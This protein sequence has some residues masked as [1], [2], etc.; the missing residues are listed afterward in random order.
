MYLKL[1]FG[2]MFSGKTSWL[3]N[4]HKNTHSPDDT[5]FIN[6]SF[7]FNRNPI[8]YCISHDNIQCATKSFFCTTLSQFDTHAI[9]SKN[10]KNIFINEGQ[11]FNDLDT[12]LTSIQCVDINVWVSGLD[13]DYKQN[14]FGKI[15]AC[16]PLSDEFNRLYS[17]CIDCSGNAQ[18]TKR[19]YNNNCTSS[20]NQILIGNNDVYA[21]VCR[22]CYF[23]NNLN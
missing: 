3:I 20:N 2:P 12:W 11:F 8:E 4:E 5:I 9:I 7:E 14:P 16:I 23:K 17:K 6:H 13:Y 1:A 10:I 15:L 22:L 18:Y 21:P 19:I